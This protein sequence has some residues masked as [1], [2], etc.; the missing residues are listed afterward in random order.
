MDAAGAGR[1][2]RDPRGMMREA[3]FVILEEEILRDTATVLTSYVSRYHASSIARTA[4][5]RASALKGFCRKA[6]PFC[7]AASAGMASSV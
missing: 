2:K 3:W 4:D 6:T 5:A 1:V 7:E